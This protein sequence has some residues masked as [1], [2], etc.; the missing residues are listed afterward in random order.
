MILALTI[1]LKTFMDDSCFQSLNI[2]TICEPILD[3][4]EKSIK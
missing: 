3:M 4:D 1:L 2:T